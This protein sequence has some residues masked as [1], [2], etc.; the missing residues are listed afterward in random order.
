MPTYNRA[1]CIEKAINSLLNQIYQNFELIIIDDGSTDN[2]E[3]LVMD[4]YKELIKSKKIIYIRF[5][6]NQGVSKARNKGLQLAKYEWVAY[7]DSD[8]EIMSNYLVEYVRAIKQNSDKKIFYAK[9]Q[10]SDSKIIGKPFNYK[11][12]VEKNFI[13]MGVFVHKKSLIKQ[14]GNFD[15]KLKRGVD[16]DLIIRYTK[17]NQPVFID[18]IL[19]KYNCSNDFERI[20]NT[21][22]GLVNSIYI[23]SKIFRKLSF[24]EQIFSIK[25]SYDRRH[26]IIRLLGIK[27]KFKRKQK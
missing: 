12:L 23:K 13:D 5:R 6:K 7:L 25:N 17:N 27:I 9:L 1:F 21:Q 11:D 18:K 19:L 22:D 4:K 15:T 10:R 16:W 8:N 2:T 14:Y 20:S 26:K 3:A 24:L